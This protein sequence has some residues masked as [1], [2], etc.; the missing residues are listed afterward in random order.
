MP[1]TSFVMVVEIHNVDAP[2]TSNRD[3]T[4]LSPTAGTLQ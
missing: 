3:A 2:V 1:S 4:V